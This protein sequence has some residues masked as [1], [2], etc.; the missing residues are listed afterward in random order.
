[1]KTQLVT[2][3]LL[4]SMVLGK[5]KKSKEDKEREEA[6]KK[7]DI[8]DYSD[9]DM[10]TLLEQWEEGDDPIPPDELPLGHPD[11]PQPMMDFSKLDPSNP[12]NIIAASKKGRSVMLFATLQGVTDPDM[13]EE[14]SSLWQTGLGN[15]HIPSERLM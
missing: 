11:R 1:M 7:K 14:L 13:A 5:K 3:L 4:T 6:L 12:E 10:A 2:V 8:R 15:N 9:S